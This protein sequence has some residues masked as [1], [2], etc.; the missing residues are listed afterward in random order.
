MQRRVLRVIKPI[1]WLRRECSV[2]SN[3]NDSRRIMNYWD[4][5]VVKRKERRIIGF[6]KV[7][8]LKKNSDRGLIKKKKSKYLKRSF[9][10]HDFFAIFDGRR[11]R[12]SW[13]Q[14][15]KRKRPFLT[16]TRHGIGVLTLQ[17]TRGGCWKK[18]ETR[19]TDAGTVKRSVGVGRGRRM[20]SFSRRPSSPLVGNGRVRRR[21]LTGR[22]RGYSRFAFALSIGRDL[23]V[24]PLVVGGALQKETTIRRQMTCTIVQYC[25][26][27][28][29]KFPTYLFFS[30]PIWSVFYFFFHRNTFLYRCVFFY[31]TNK[32]NLFK[33][34]FR[35]AVTVVANVQTANQ[36]KS[37]EYRYINQSCHCMLWFDIFQKKSIIIGVIYLYW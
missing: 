10:A 24:R 8:R 14:R 36:R 17:M 2:R 37:I 15:S 3:L 26:L 19:K 6:Y 11:M 5:R 18:P 20:F 31:K 21:C 35:F 4:R 32:N 7:V 13:K 28:Y 1:K 9:R 12:G 16:C 30:R 34:R 27:S 29:R 22:R 23:A 25:D 33:L